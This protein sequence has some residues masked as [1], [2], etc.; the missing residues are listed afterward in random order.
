MTLC[1][2]EQLARNIINSEEADKSSNNNNIKIINNNFEDKRCQL[3]LG[4]GQ[5]QPEEEE[6]CELGAELGQ[7]QGLLLSGL[8][9]RLTLLYNFFKAKQL[10]RHNLDQDNMCAKDSFT[11][12]LINTSLEVKY[13]GGKIIKYD[14]IS[15][16]VKSSSTTA[17]V[18]I[19]EKKEGLHVVCESTTENRSAETS[20]P[21]QPQLSTA[22]H[23]EACSK[24]E[25]CSSDEG[26]VARW[27]QR[28][29][30]RRRTLQH[31]HSCSE[32]WRPFQHVE[33]WD[34]FDYR[35]EQVREC[36]WV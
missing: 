13:S 7:Q 30:C 4:N 8:Q 33:V 21:L 18:I 34:D 22:F 1:L 32:E 17:S 23:S 27:K 5:A 19:N 6:E 20:K 29:E 16:Y 26:R 3:L 14:G 11:K 12:D 25:N 35:N 9:Q 28:R 2:R 10:N 24:I 36:K 31:N 15:D